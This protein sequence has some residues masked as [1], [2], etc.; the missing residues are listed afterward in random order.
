MDDTEKPQKKDS[1]GEKSPFATTTTLVRDEIFDSTLTK[2]H[3]YLKIPGFGEG[4][5]FVELGEGDITIGRT[6]ECEIQLPVEGVSR[7]H[8]L[9]SFHN[10]EYYVEDLDSKNGT[11]LNNVK[12][13]KCILRNKDQIDICGVKIIF[14]EVTSLTET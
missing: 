1:P 6:S 11:Y 7:K 13:A 14:N 4:T 2:L 3:A 8:A 10:E 9:I 5:E 12:I